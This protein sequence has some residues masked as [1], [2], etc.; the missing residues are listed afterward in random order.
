MSKLE[1]AQEPIISSTVSPTQENIVARKTVVYETLID[2]AVIR[3]AAE[4]NKNKL[5]AKYLL[6]IRKP[7]E[8]EFVS[9]D[10]YYEPFLAVSGIYSID[11]YR[12]SAYTVKIDKEVKE[13][14]LLDE[15][16]V[17]AP[18]PN[19]RSSEQ[20]LYLAGEER[21]I[22]EN[23]LFL[24]LDR[25]GREAKPGELAS[26]PSEKNPGK[27]VE[28]LGLPEIPADM[29]VDAV[30][31]RIQRRPADVNRIVSE[32]FEVS[33]RTLIYAP[34]FRVKYKSQKVGKEAFMDFDGVNSNLLTK[35]LNVVSAMASAVVLNGKRVFELAV[36]SARSMVGRLV[37]SCSRFI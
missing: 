7:D 24:L 33:E 14:I 15:T 37:N 11:Y 31:N 30:R 10:K 32:L 3:V 28:L 12:K 25:W 5:F 20:S 9:I 16:F 8:I 21:L 34:R 4:Q 29:E 6:Q 27:L 19:P 26:G 23:K 13:V 1:Y 17:P 22:K 35:N 2:P 36:K 18:T